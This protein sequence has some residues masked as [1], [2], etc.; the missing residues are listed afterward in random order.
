L[1]GRRRPE[2]T[3]GD[4]RRPEETG[5]DRRRPEETGG[6]NLKLKKKLT[7]FPPTLRPLR[8]GSR[9]RGK[10]QN[11]KKKSKKKVG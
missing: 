4:R 7:E 10:F 1:P 6:D 9:R 2:E 8:G 11:K 5:G 3:G